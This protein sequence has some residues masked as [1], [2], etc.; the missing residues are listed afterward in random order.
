MRTLL[1]IWGIGMAGGMFM[2]TRSTSVVEALVWLTIAVAF[3]RV[4]GCL[5]WSIPPAISQRKDV[6]TI[7]GC[8]NLAGNIAGVLTPIIIGFIISMTGSYN[9][10]LLLFVCFGLGVSAASLF[11]NYGRK[12]GGIPSVTIDVSHAAPAE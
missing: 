6:G 4:A 12:I 2:V 9:L 3:E 5:Y 7:A 10:A 1:V 8:M 11:I